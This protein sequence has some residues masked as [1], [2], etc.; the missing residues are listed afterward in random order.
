MWGSRGHEQIIERQRKMQ[1]SQS[2]GSHNRMGCL[3]SSLIRPLVR[4][5]LSII[6]V[7]GSVGNASVSLQGAFTQIRKRW[8]LCVDTALQAHPA[9]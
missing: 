8:P 2:R 1:N 9:S 4:R 5:V 6:A 3:W 7:W